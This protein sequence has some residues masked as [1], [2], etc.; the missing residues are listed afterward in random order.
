MSAHLDFIK[1][2]LKTT[3][4]KDPKEHSEDLEK[5]SEDTEEDLLRPTKYMDGESIWTTI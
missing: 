5:D 4:S 1:K 3:N 2:T